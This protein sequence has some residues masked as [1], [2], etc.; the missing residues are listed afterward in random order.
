MSIEQ[1]SSHSPVAYS[2]LFLS[3]FAIQGQ[4]SDFVTCFWIYQSRIGW[5]FW[6]VTEVAFCFFFFFSFRLNIPH[7]ALHIHLTTYSD[8]LEMF[9]FS[10]LP[11]VCYR[12][13][14]FPPSYG[15]KSQPN[16]FPPE[17]GGTPNRPRRSKTGHVAMI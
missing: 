8:D 14:I 10:V 9:I 6:H 16:F 5:R 11:G 1:R 13:H 7:L 4:V 15:T 3:V 17:R 12:C 2:S